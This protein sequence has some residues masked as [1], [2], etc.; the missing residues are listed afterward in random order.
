MLTKISWTSFAPYLPALAIVAVGGWVRFD[1]ITEQGISQGDCFEYVAEAKR[2]AEG[3]PPDFLNGYFY[4]PA[5]YFLQG[6]AIRLG[7][8]NDY[9]I[10]ILNASLDVANIVLLFIIAS[11]L[12]RTAW[13]GVFAITVFSFL[14]TPIYYARSEMVHSESAFFVLLA[15][16][17]FLF[18][19]HAFEKQKKSRFGW[20]T[21]WLVVSGVFLGIAANTHADLAFLAPGFA[22]YLF[23]RESRRGG[24]Q[25]VLWSAIPQ[26]ALYSVAFFTPYIV[27]VAAF[28][29]SEVMRV[30]RNEISLAENHIIMDTGHEWKLLIFFN[31]FRYSFQRCF[32]NEWPIGLVF[33]SVLPIMAWRRWRRREDLPLASLPLVLLFLYALIYSAFAS[34]FGWNFARLFIPLMPL[35]LFTVAYWYH[36]S[37]Q[38][39]AGRFAV[40]PL[41][42]LGIGLFWVNPKVLPGQ[43][44]HE[45]PYRGIHGILGDVVDENHKLLIAPAIMYYRDR[46]FQHDLYFNKNAQYLIDFSLEG[47]Y[48]VDN[49]E[50][51]FGEQ[52]FAFLLL[53]NHLDQRMLRPDWP[54]SE[55]QKTWLHSPHF[56]YNV[57]K[58]RE[59]LLKWVEQRGGHL[60]QNTRWGSLYSL[61]SEIHPKLDDHKSINSPMELLQNGTFEDWPLWKGIPDHWTLRSGAV[62]K[63][64]EAKGGRFALLFEP[65][66]STLESGSRVMF[67]RVDAAPGRGSLLE[68]SMDV[69]SSEPGMLSF[70]VQALVDGQ[71]ATISR[72]PNSN[73]QWINAAGTGEWERLRA[74]IPLTPN[75]DL[76]RLALYIMLRPGAK[77]PALVDNV[78]IVLHP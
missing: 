33:L 16:L 61:T 42:A 12:C 18:Y 4:R 76:G 63:G 59:T 34:S 2:W 37:A 50:R 1:G 22:L 31:I 55:N 21:A 10:K 56:E 77:G 60:I 52:P 49:L 66:P 3:Q 58:E 28:G 13:A 26:A 30:F 24:T 41:L 7:G 71:P 14:P 15:L 62:R 43:L 57:D 38:E 51:V 54:L 25:A 19:D 27:G 73:S 44:D 67:S 53:S 75:I 5:V 45:T 47:D 65:P 32:G 23:W 11:I 70:M 72:N 68:V 6:W 17:F 20:S 29:W 40:L 69:K 35:V 39:V 48:T 64:R 74:E 36:K 8:Y 78:S 46:G 9:S